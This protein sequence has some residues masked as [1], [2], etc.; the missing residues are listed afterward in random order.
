MTTINEP[1]WRRLARFSPQDAAGFEKLVEIYLSS[2][3]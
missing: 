3:D 1:S 2:V